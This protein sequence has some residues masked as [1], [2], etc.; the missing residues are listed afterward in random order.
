MD[1]SP[2]TKL[3]FFRGITYAILWYFSIWTGFLFVCCPLWIFI[4]LFPKK[5]LPVMSVAFSIWEMYPVAL[6]NLIFGTKIRITGDRINAKEI[7]VIITNHRTRIDWNFMWAAMYYACQPQTHRLKI[8]LKAPLRHMPSL[9][10]VMQVAN[11]IYLQR[12]WE[13]DRI[14]MKKQMEF[15]HDIGLE[16]QI[17]LFPEGTDL[18]KNSLDKSNEFAKKNN[19]PPYTQVLHPRTTGFTFLVDTM[20][21]KKLN[22]NAI[23]DVTLAYSGYMPQTETDVIRGNFPKTVHFHINRY[24]IESLPKDQDDLKSWINERWKEKENRLIEFHKHDCFPSTSYYTSEM[25]NS[26]YLAFI[27]WTV[28]EFLM[29]YFFITSS[30]FF[31]WT[32]LHTVLFVGIS[33]ATLGFQNLTVSVFEYFHNTKKSH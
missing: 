29:F 7:S 21:S 23:Y 12:K 4:L 13:N 2:G 3:R 5:F 8:A 19:L 6:M 14:T 10:W 26:L 30:F 22:I 18:T 1:S 32:V 15:F 28:L 33:Y 17:L 27:V 20:R 25:D 9:G 31:W 24:P 16:F 11:C